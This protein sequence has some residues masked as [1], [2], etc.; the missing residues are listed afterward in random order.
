MRARV[1]QAVRMGE[2]DIR[3]IAQQSPAM[4]KSLVKATHENAVPRK[5]LSECTSHHRFSACTRATRTGAATTHLST[6]GP[7]HRWQRL[8]CA[9]TPFVGTRQHPASPDAP[10][11]DNSDFNNYVY[12]LSVVSNRCAAFG[13]GCASV[14]PTP[15]PPPPTPQHTWKPPSIHGSPQ[16]SMETSIQGERERETPQGDTPGRHPRENPRGKR[17]PSDG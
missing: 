14:P 5:T 12:V 15:H 11:A 1:P 8:C 3:A 7:A 2:G 17:S 13:R 6:R 10:A 9:R 16:A 4:R